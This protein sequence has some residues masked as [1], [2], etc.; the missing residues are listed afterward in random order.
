MN[1]VDVDGKAEGAEGIEQRA[2]L[3]ARMSASS[4]AW[5]ISSRATFIWYS[6]F[7]RLKVSERSLSSCCV[8]EMSGRVELSVYSGAVILV[9]L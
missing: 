2:V 3:S 5:A 1:P 7:S 9:E 6:W 4:L 8:R